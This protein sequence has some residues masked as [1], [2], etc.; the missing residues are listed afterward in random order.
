VSH[1][2]GAV[3]LA[4]GN[5]TVEGGATLVSKGVTSGGGGIWTINGTQ[6]LA[7]GTGAVATSKV[8]AVPVIDGSTGQL[9]IT[10]QKVIVQSTGATGNKA[11]LLAAVQAAVLVGKNTSGTL[12]TGHGITSSVVAG[13]IPGTKTTIAVVD[14]G[15]YTTPKSMFGGV[16]VDSNSILV[17]RALVG[18]VNLDNS[19]TTADLNTLVVNYGK[20]GVTWAS[21]DVTGDGNVTTAD[22]NA[23]LAND[24]QTLEGGFSFL[25]SDDDTSVVAFEGLSGGVTAVPEASTVGVLAL[26]VVGMLGRRRRRNEKS[27]LSG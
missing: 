26:G 18:D 16:A 1:T 2:V 9:D 12:W 24:G 10:N 5:L 7:Y 22:L 20:T 27:L 6:Q 3:S 11:T 23:L 25:P 15:A 8:D 17:T 19:V 13:E 21:G 4:G 14:N